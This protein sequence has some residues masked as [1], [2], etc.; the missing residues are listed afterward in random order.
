MRARNIK[1]GF[2]KNELL[3]SGDPLNQ[4]VYEG[5][6]CLADSEGRLEDRPLRI[7]VEVNPY[8][9]PAGTTGSLNWL[10]EKGFVR[11]Y[12][13]DGVGYLQILAFKK[14]QNPHRN[15]SGRCPA[16][17]GA[18]QPADRGSEA[19]GQVASAGHS[20]SMHES[21]RK[22]IGGVPEHSEKNMS[23]PASSLNPSSLNPSS[24]NPESSLRSSS[25][26]DLSPSSSG[27]V[28]GGRR[29]TVSKNR[30]E[31]KRKVQA[32]VEEVANLKRLA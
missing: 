17:N 22:T 31:K 11:R 6:W 15:E 20:S 12:T 10:T 19:T 18:D 5:L 16:P 14:H 30:E 9:D 26:G 1:P 3:G 32:L 23:A 25:S 8:R 29:K 2:F 21:H 24:L 13:V 27:G 7:H 4:V 28:R